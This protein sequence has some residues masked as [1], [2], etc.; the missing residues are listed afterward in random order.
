MVAHEPVDKPK[1]LKLVDEF[2][3]RPKIPFGEPEVT[4][5]DW[6]AA[7]VE[8]RLHDTTFEPPC[9]ADKTLAEV[10]RGHV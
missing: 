4:V 6:I 7:V 1:R 5:S 2:P 8:P 3:R 10:A 9:G